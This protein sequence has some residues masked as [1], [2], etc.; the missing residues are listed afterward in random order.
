MADMIRQL[1]DLVP[2]PQVGDLRLQIALRQLGDRLLQL[3]DGA[4]QPPGQ[5]QTERVL[6]SM[7]MPRIW[8]G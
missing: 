6:T 4:G 7:A 3:Q 5:Q 8:I 1:A 2:P